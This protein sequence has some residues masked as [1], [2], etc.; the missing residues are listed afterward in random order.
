MDIS[1]IFGG[2]KVAGQV[3]TAAFV[4]IALLVLYFIAKKAIRNFRLRNVGDSTDSNFNPDSLANTVHEAF[5]GWLPSGE[6]MDAVS[7][8][9]LALSD[10]KLKAVNDRYN[11]LF[12]KSGETMY[13]KI[14]SRVCM[15]CG[16]RDAI[17]VRLQGLGL[18]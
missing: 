2:S 11:D 3:A 1:K 16:N 15:F 7:A 9:L 14:D 10:E 6:D 13:T 12:G 5:T 4:L 8:R 17:L 18:G